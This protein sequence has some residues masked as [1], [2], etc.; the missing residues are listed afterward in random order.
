MSKEDNKSKYDISN[1]LYY[2]ILAK[3]PDVARD[4]IRNEGTREINYGII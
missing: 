2:N 4:S 1:T 3:I